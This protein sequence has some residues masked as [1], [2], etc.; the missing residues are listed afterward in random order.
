[1]DHVRNEY[2]GDMEVGEYYAAYESYEYQDTTN[3]SGYEPGVIPDPGPAVTR[4]WSEAEDIVLPDDSLADT[5]LHDHDLIDSVMY[6]YFGSSSHT[7]GGAGKQILIIGAAIS[8]VAQFLSLA[9]ILRR[10]RSNSHDPAT[11][12]FINTEL[13]LSA[14]NFIL[15]ISAQA[16]G[17]QHWCES[18]ALLLHY[19]HLVASC[20]LFSVGLLAYRRL[21]EGP[22]PSGLCLHFTLAW[23]LPAIHVLVCYTVNPRGYET[24]HYCWMSVERG[25]LLSYMT[26]VASLILANTILSVLGLR[27]LSRC[28]VSHK[29]CL[30]ENINTIEEML[31]KSLRSAAMLLPLFAVTWFLGVLAFENS[32]TLFFPVLFAAADIFLNWFLYIYSSIVLPPLLILQ[33]EQ[34][35]NKTCDIE[36]LLSP[37]ITPIHTSS[38][39][40]PITATT[41]GGELLELR[42]DSI[43]TISS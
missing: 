3:N 35:D 28:D 1:M 14:C 18:V 9:T 39:A 22:C 31:R 4:Q 32:A 10:L 17:K 36:P 38:L 37:D 15:M 19:L 30:L 41:N 5:D 2:A 12:I 13:S 42:L 21:N 29:L 8:L 33:E 23:L 25:M 24:R 6:I 34:P 11:F 16:T 26:P 27:M 7:E 43:S 20:W 40:H